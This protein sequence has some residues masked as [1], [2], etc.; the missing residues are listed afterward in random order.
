MTRH[1]TGV[2]SGNS[3][4][5]RGGCGSSKPLSPPAFGR[6]AG[7]RKLSARGR[8]KSRSIW[9]VARVLPGMFCLHLLA[10]Q[11]LRRVK[12]L[13]V[14]N[15]YIH[16]PALVLAVCCPGFCLL[17]GLWCD[18]YRGRMDRGRIYSPAL[19]SARMPALW[20]R[21]EP[22]LTSKFATHFT[23][24]KH[25]FGWL[26]CLFDPAHVTMRGPTSPNAQTIFRRETDV[27]T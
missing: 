5:Q 9:G 19:L 8:C 18:R 6:Q 14:S 4:C 12:M 26:D 3:C 13:S 23:F 21:G 16:D 7:W 17:A 22:A 10:V 27:E 1:G 11:P 15:G 25:F 20:L 2:S 24:Y